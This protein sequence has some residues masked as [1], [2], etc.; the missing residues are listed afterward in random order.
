MILGGYESPYVPYQRCVNWKSQL[1]TNLLSSDGLTK[2]VQIDAIVKHLETGTGLPMFTKQIY[3]CKSG[4]RQSVCGISRD[5]GS[6]QLPIGASS[7]SIGA[8]VAARVAM[9]N[10]SGNALCVGPTQYGPR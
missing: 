5:A 1:M 4:R 3:S 6:H 9:G 8:I 7:Q 2:R 10:A